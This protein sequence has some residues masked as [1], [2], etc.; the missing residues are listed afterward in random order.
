MIDGSLKTLFIAVLIE[1]VYQLLYIAYF[2]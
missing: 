1:R 2:R